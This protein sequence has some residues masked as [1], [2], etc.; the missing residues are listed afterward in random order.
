M[1]VYD[2]VIKKTWDLLK[3][4]DYQELKL[5][6]EIN[7][8]CLTNNEFLMDRDIAFELGDR[9]KPCTVYN[10]QTSDAS[11]ISNDRILLLGKNLNEIDENTNFS[12]IT[13]FNV[14]EV[15]DANKAYI[16]IKRLEYERFKMIP[17]GYMILSSSLANKENIRVSKKAVEQGIS[18]EIIGNL[19]LNHYKK[20]EGVN[21]VWV[22]FLVGD[23]PFMGDL[24]DLSKE[25]DEITNAYDHILKNVI[26][27]CEVCP[28]KPICEDVEALREL[29]FSRIDEKRKRLFEKK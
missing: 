28:L 3:N 7:W 16:G 9:D 1:N 11:M 15:A 10:A 24:V 5:N 13:L 4:H 8:K 14:D 12:R 19:Y 27:D 29:H 2:H 17:E 26:L 23:Y 21:H 22:I 6:T 20:L 25:V 18:F